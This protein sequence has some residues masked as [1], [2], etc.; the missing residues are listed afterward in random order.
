MPLP[1]EPLTRILKM[2]AIVIVFVHGASLSAIALLAIAYAALSL[3]LGPIAVFPLAVIAVPVL[4]VYSISNVFPARISLQAVDGIQTALNQVWGANELHVA[5]VALIASLCGMALFYLYK[6]CWHFLR[7]YSTD[8][9]AADIGVPFW[10][11]QIMAVAACISFVVPIAIWQ[12]AARSAIVS[13]ETWYLLTFLTPTPEIGIAIALLWLTKGP[14]AGI[15]VLSPR[16]A[17]GAVLLLAGLYAVL[18]GFRFQLVVKEPIRHAHEFYD[19]MHKR[20]ARIEW[21]KDAPLRAQAAHEQAMKEYGQR[22]CQAD[23]VG[24]GKIQHIRQVDEADRRIDCRKCGNFKEYR[25]MVKIKEW[26]YARTDK[27]TTYPLEMRYLTYKL[28]KIEDAFGEERLITATTL[29]GKPG[30]V[31]SLRRAEQSGLPLD[32][33]AANTGNDPWQYER[34]LMLSCQRDKERQ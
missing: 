32:A 4:M 5:M 26:L 15:H 31:L 13:R 8:E 29:S 2:L 22:L 21:E 3:V 6:Y 16:L 9:P 25:V 1:L 28:D 27:E 19:A 14:K 34:K 12:G 18:C 33:S 10:Q 23:Y 20:T 11:W 7:R 30:S 24:V 17:V